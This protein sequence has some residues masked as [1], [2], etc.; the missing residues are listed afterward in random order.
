M[1]EQAKNN[2]ASTEAQMQMFTHAMY[3]VSVI[4]A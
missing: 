4:P 2:Q 3:G 1:F